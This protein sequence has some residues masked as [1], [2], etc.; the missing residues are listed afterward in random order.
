[1]D[2]ADIKQA[3][4]ELMSRRMGGGDEGAIG[5]RPGHTMARRRRTVGGADEQ[6]VSGDGTTVIGRMPENKMEITPPLRPQTDVT[7]WIDQNLPLLQGIDFSQ[8]VIDYPA[9]TT[10]PPP[11]TTTTPGP[12]TT[13]S[14]TTTPPPTTTTTA[15]PTTTTPPPTTTT[16]PPTTTT[17]PPTTTT[18][19]PTTTTPPPPPPTTTTPPP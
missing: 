5:W 13:T 11:T 3:K 19:P 2:D 16:P 1:M 15:A 18:A 4:Q 7:N 9:T 8:L 10:T 12:T 14:T 17:P 6:V